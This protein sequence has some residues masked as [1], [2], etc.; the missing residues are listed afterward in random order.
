MRLGKALVQAGIPFTTITNAPESSLARLAERILWV[1]SYQDQLV[2]INIISS[3]MTA[4]LAAGS[5]SVWRFAKPV[6]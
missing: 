2:S 4:T 6:G 5:R 3:M 1:N